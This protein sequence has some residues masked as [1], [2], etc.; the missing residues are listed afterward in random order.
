MPEL[1]LAQF[2]EVEKKLVG[3]LQARDLLRFRS[4]FVVVINDLL[5]EK[6]PKMR[7]SYQL[8]QITN[9]S[10][11]ETNALARDIFKELL[12]DAFLD[13][14]RAGEQQDSEVEVSPSRQTRKILDLKDIFEA[15]GVEESAEST[16]TQEA[17]QWKEEIASIRAKKEVDEKKA[18]DAILQS[19]AMEFSD[20]QKKK[21]SDIIS[22]RIK[23]IRDAVDTRLVLGRPVESGGL[24]LSGEDASEVSVTIE[25]YLKE[26]LP[27]ASE[28]NV[29]NVPPPA[30]ADVAQKDANAL[31]DI[32]S[33]KQVDKITD[34]QHENVTV[35]KSVEPKPIKTDRIQPVP[36]PSD[37]RKPG[38]IPTFGLKEKR[39][40][41]LVGPIEELQQ[42]TIEDWRSLYKSIDE[43]VEK[44]KE[45][46]RTLK[47]ESFKEMIRGIN[48]WKKGNIMKLYAAV[49]A[50]SVNDHM[51]IA[52]NAEMHKGKNQS[53]L[54]EEEFHAIMD[55]NKDLRSYS[56]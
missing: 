33:D 52:E 1:S 55:F 22:S 4:K 14:A 45:Q 7:L 43:A 11:K 46:L 50:E 24:G 56:I 35:E 37:N 5:N 18:V 38:D 21:L 13:S 53:Y 41:G 17:Q 51:T 27:D 30:P 3:F 28:S 49:G 15:D 44:T 8:Y 16:D 26:P 20:D 29:E 36:Q 32:F 54:T 25:R 10:L 6:F 40:A 47:G 39:E 31:E 2:P 9:L 42:V 48:A 19:L 12:T 34:E 23:N